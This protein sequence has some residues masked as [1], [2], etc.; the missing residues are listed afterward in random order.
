MEQAIAR[1]HQV[2]AFVRHPDKAAHL[3]KAATIV[4]GD[5]L[6][7][8]AVAKAVPGHDTVII[9]V[10]DAR[11][12]VSGPVTRNA[13]AAM[14]AAGVRRI[15]LLAA[16]GIGDS[17]HGLYGFVMSRLLGK[18]NADKL[19]SEAA[20]ESSGLDWTAVRAPVLGEAPATHKLVAGPSN[21]RVSGFRAISRQDLAAFMLD[22][23]DSPTF[24]RKKPVVSQG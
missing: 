10:G 6:D 19:A 4:Q 21:A 5:G 20:L 24:V 18:L 11:T 16:Y 9:T 1:G 8:I 14:K 13:V 12:Y 7:A 2:T 15:I 3:P 23:I 22:Q 17:A